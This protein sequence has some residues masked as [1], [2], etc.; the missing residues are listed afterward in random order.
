MYEHMRD[1]KSVLLF[2]GWDP[3]GQAEWANAATGCSPE[4]WGRACGWFVLAIADMLDHIPRSI[5]SETL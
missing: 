4:I 2:H 1:E 5:R 3:T